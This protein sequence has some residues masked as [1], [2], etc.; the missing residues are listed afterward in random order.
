MRPLRYSIKVGRAARALGEG[1]VYV[2]LGDKP[3]AIA[4][5]ERAYEVHDGGLVLLASFPL[6]A[7]LHGE[8]GYESLR[9]RLKL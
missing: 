1:T 4:W 2:G 3:N 9:R 8:P 5:L 7:P 6:W